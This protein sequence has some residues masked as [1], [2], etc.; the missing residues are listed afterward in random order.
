[1]ADLN[2]LYRSLPALHELDCEPTG[3][4]WLIMHDAEHSIFAWLRKGRETRDRCLVVVNFTPEVHRDYRIKVPFAGTWREV[5]NTDA[6]I[7]GG[8]N[9]GNGGAVN[10]LSQGPIPEVSLVIPPLAAVFLVPEF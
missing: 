2:K 5:L 3:F 9:L 10:T 6:Q 4:E 7:Y 1:V 8:T